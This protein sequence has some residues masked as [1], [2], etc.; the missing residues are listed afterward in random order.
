MMTASSASQ[1]NMPTSFHGGHGGHG[2]GGGGAIGRASEDVDASWRTPQEEQTAFVDSPLMEGAPPRKMSRSNM[3]DV[4][5]FRS[6]P[7]WPARRA[8]FAEN[9]VG[10]AW[11]G[12][13]SRAPGGFDPRS[14]ALRRSSTGQTSMVRPAFNSA[15]SGGSAGVDSMHDVGISSPR[16]SNTGSGGFNRYLMPSRQSQPSS[17]SPNE[18]SDISPPRRLMDQVDEEGMMV[19]EDDVGNALTMD[20]PSPMSGQRRE[21]VAKR[22]SL[23]V[24]RDWRRAQKG[25]GTADDMVVGDEEAEE[26]DSPTE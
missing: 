25:S 2:G 15:G 16:S 1:S 11:T 18:T 5:S 3:E 24:T 8:S 23:S 9:G 22:G 4:T 26:G 10:D 7:T 19:T 14:E 21:S 13:N 17:R 6:Q 12:G 20:D